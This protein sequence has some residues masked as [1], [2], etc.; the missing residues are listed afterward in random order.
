MGQPSAPVRP[1]LAG[2]VFQS[3][4]IP[5]TQKWRFAPEGQHLELGIAEI[6]CSC[7]SGPVTSADR[8]NAGWHGA[9]QAGDPGASCHVERLLAQ[10]PKGCGLVTAI[11]GHPVTLGWMSGVMGQRTTPLGVEHFGHTG[12]VADLYRHFEIDAQAIAAAARVFLSKGRP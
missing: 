10:V 1:R 12:S 3:E 5:S 6:N 2:D 8:L 11:D 4:Q 7:C 9:Q